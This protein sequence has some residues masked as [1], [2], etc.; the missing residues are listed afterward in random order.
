MLDTKIRE[1]LLSAPGLFE[2]P[3]PGEVL[4]KAWGHC[5]AECS[6]E[7]F[8]AALNRSGYVVDVVVGRY[9]LALPSP[10]I[11][12]PNHFNMPRLG[13]ARDRRDGLR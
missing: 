13:N 12:G 9:R 4:R 10:S 1:W 5:G 6:V 2:A 11:S 7:E 8:R 3:T